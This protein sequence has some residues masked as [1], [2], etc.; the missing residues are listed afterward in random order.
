LLMERAHDRLPLLAEASR[1]RGAT[2]RH[3]TAARQ[4]ISKLAGCARARTCLSNCR[5]ARWAVT[6]RGRERSGHQP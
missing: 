1:R 4:S 3:G 6:I 5:R 2:A